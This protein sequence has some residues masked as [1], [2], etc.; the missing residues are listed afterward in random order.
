MLR[1]LINWI[2]LCCP[3]IHYKP[4]GGSTENNGQSL[5]FLPLSLGQGSE[6]EEN[7]IFITLLT[8]NILRLVLQFSMTSRTFCPS[9]VDFLIFFSPFL[10]SS[11]LRKY[12]NHMICI[13]HSYLPSCSC[14]SWLLT[15]FLSSMCWNYKIILGLQPAILWTQICHKT[16]NHWFTQKKKYVTLIFIFR[17]SSNYSS[18]TCSTDYSVYICAV[19][20][21]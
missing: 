20:N 15:K 19:V 6:S 13:V 2:A 21:R 8:K 1:R 7:I 9:F 10:S 5:M 17:L 11:Y 4:L 14:I 12:C 16:C 3:H 18:S